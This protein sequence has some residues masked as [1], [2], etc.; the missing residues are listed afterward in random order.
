M[1]IFP[2]RLLA[3]EDVIFHLNNLD[4]FLNKVSPTEVHLVVKDPHGQEIARYA[5]HFLRR[6]SLELA[7]ASSE[8][9]PSLPLHL[10]ARHLGREV[11]LI[12]FYRSHRTGTHYYMVHEMSKDCV[13]GKYS[14]EVEAYNDGVMTGSGTAEY[15]YFFI[16]DVTVSSFQAS[17]D[18]FKASV[19]NGSPEPTPVRVVEFGDS[20]ERCQMRTIVLAPGSVTEVELGDHRALMYYCED[21]KCSPLNRDESPYVLRNQRYRAV[22]DPRSENPGDTMYLV[23]EADDGAFELT[24]DALEIWNKANGVFRKSEIVQDDNRELYGEMLREGLI[25]ELEGDYFT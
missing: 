16:D 13:P 18:G 3:G 5:R 21:R 20:E 12:E 7:R 1:S 8:Q 17:D 14:L 25:Y 11:D 19:R 6:P 22:S 9:P 10:L 4:T 24:G 23:E 2:R 15:D